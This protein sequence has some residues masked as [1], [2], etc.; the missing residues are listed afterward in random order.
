MATKRT[1]NEL[2]RKFKSARRAS[3]PILTVA[4]PDPAAMMRAICAASD[5]QPRN[6][7][8]RKPTPKISWDIVNGFVHLNEDGLAALALIGKQGPPNPVAALVAALRF[9]ERTILFLL[10]AHRFLGDCTV[11][12]AVWNLRDHWKTNKRTLVLLG[13][14]AGIKLPDELRNGDVLELDEPLPDEAELQRLV[15]SEFAK[16]SAMEFVADEA[17]VTRA[18]AAMKGCSAFGAE[19]LLWM[20]VDPTTGVSFDDLNES[21]RKTIEQ[22]PGLSYEAG[23]ETFADVGGL[24]FAKSFGSQLFAGPRRPSLVVRVEELEK[25]M[26]GAGGDL[27]GT[28]QDALQVLLSDMEDNE[29]SGL[30]AVGAPGCLHADTPIHDPVDGTT[31]TVA[32]REQLGVGFHVYSRDK[33][34]RVVVAR[35]AKPWKYA[36]AEMVRFTMSSGDKITVTLGHRFWDGQRYA[37]AS[38]V[39]GRLQKFG[40]VRLPTI[41]DID[42]Q[43]RPQDAPRSTHTGQ[44]FRVGYQDRFCFGGEPLLSGEVAGQSWTPLRSDAQAR[45]QQQ[46][47][48]GGSDGEG[49]RT[50]RKSCGPLASTDCARL[51]S[52]VVGLLP[53]QQQ[54]R[55]GRDCGLTASFAQFQ[56]E[57]RQSRRS[58]LL[59]LVFPVTTHCDRIAPSALSVEVG[60]PHIA[61]ALRTSPQYR[62]STVQPSTGQSTLP[63]SRPASCQPDA[64]DEAS[65][66]C[67]ATPET[68]GSCLCRAERRH[69]QGTGQKRTGGLRSAS[70]HL[71]SELDANLLRALDVSYCV[72]GTDEY[73][74]VQIV[75]FEFVGSKPYYDFHVPAYS[76]YFACGC[77]HHNSGKSL[78]SKSLARTFD[79]RPL[80]FDLNACKG[81]LV[82]E[83]G[84]KIRAAMKVI[85]TIGG[86]NVFFIASVNRLE[87]LPP[88]LQRRFRC[89]VWYFDIPGPADRKRIWEIQRARWSVPKAD[90]IPDDTDLTGADIRNICEVAYSLA[91]P[92][93]E[94]LRYVVPLKVQSPDA[95]RECR[96]QANGRFIDA[97]AGGVYRIDQTAPAAGGRGVMDE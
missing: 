62:E 77:F 28:S 83:S 91:I 54:E 13:P 56:P 61:G 37:S 78:F 1:D 55:R 53:R 44:G 38:E 57:S 68:F 52:L 36:P 49:E 20:S 72:G 21:V 8:G 95:I 69:S 31:R 92:L 51:P 35:A 63:V 12:Q 29:W 86:S 90:K 47:L 27:S 11:M 76:N 10:N 25:S 2:V 24:E 5:H 93:K 16:N 41:A 81:S 6:G 73:T 70:G 89:G 34:G 67:C 82:G 88:E 7:D 87:N 14:C 22:T 26:A 65:R 84:Q 15:R 46:L 75:G 39:V 23:K 85:K 58:Q 4:T 50:H 71:S 94:A 42:R 19:Q 60:S 3:V 48:T 32:E 66:L 74:A 79:V 40:V 30:L 43:A 96:R 33:A 64:G 59:A 18:A 97:S 17:T 9:P 45:S 80:R